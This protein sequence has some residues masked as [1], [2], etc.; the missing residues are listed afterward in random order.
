MHFSGEPDLQGQR[1]KC[2]SEKFTNKKIHMFRKYTYTQVTR[3]LKE[4]DHICIF[5]L[6]GSS[7]H[8]GIYFTKCIFELTSHAI[9]VAHIGRSKQRK[10]TK[11]VISTIKTQLYYSQ[12]NAAIHLKFTGM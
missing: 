9:S 1:L 12:L 3:H 11:G 4:I 10:V 8:G 5:I 6:K 7:L 2:I